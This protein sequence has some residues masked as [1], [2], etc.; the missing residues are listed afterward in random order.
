DD[1]VDGIPLAQLRQDAA[2]SRPMGPGAAPGGPQPLFRPD[3]PPPRPEEDIFGV[4]AQGGVA[5]GPQGSLSPVATPHSTGGTAK[6]R[7]PAPPARRGGLMLALVGALGIG[8]GALVMGLVKSG[9]PAKPAKPQPPPAVAAVLVKADA[10]VAVTVDGKHKLRTGSRGAV[11]I[12]GLAPGKHKLAFEAAGFKPQKAAFELEEGQAVLLG[13]YALERL[14]EAPRPAT[15]VIQLSDMFRDAEVS[16]DDLL[17]S[18]EKL[19]KPIEVPGGKTVS[20]RVSLLGYEDH[21]QLIQTQPGQRVET[22]PIALA[23]DRL[24][25]VAVRTAP[26]GAAITVNGKPESCVTPCRVRK[27]DPKKKFKLKLTLK[28]YR[29]HEGT[30]SFPPDERT[31]IVVVSLKEV[32]EAGSGGGS[33]APAGARLGQ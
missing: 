3:L 29:P 8:L 6:T 32:A 1:V 27:L 11:I 2:F 9:G 24:G 20:L 16:L 7:A 4:A 17:L 28:G 22:K 13:P 18:Q 19:G 15:L 25:Q 21:V 33:S 23:E 31:R 12:E 30:Y 10:D 5:P 14:E 26:V